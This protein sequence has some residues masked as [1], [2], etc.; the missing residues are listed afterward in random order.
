MKK[1][2]IL[3][4][5][6]LAGCASTDVVTFNG[7]YPSVTTQNVKIIIDNDDVVTRMECKTEQIGYI[8][9]ARMSNMSKVIN[10]AKEKAAEIGADYIKGS[11]RWNGEGEPYLNA[12]AYKCIK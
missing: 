7:S 4:V 3:A 6:L 8:S 1:L 9:T 5:L 12:T 10:V 2:M 11:F